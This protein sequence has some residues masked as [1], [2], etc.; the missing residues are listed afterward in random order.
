V[1]RS[2]PYQP[3][4]LV[5]RQV[6]ESLPTDFTPIQSLDATERALFNT[7]NLW[8]GTSGQTLSDNSLVIAAAEAL[9]PSRQIAGANPG[10]GQTLF[11]KYNPHDND[12]PAASIHWLQFVTTNAP[13]SMDQQAGV[14]FIDNNG[15]T[16]LPFYDQVFTADTTGLA[17]LSKRDVSA[18]TIQWRAELFLVQEVPMFGGLQTSYVVW[19]GL[20]WGWRTTAAPPAMA[21]VT[22]NAGPTG[23]GY[24]VTITGDGFTDATGVSFGGVAATS[25]TVNSDTSITATVPAH[26]IGTLDVAVTT[27]SGVS[28]LLLDDQFTY[29]DAAT[30]VSASANPATAG[31]TETFTANVTPDGTG[32]WYPT[33]TVSF[34]ADNNLLGTNALSGMGQATLTV[35]N[36]TA[37]QPTIT[38][39]YSGDTEFGSSSAS[40]S[41]TVNLNSVIVMTNIPG[42]V[43]A[44]QTF[45][46]AATVDGAGSA[47]PTGTV[48]FTLIDA[49]GNETQL[50]TDTVNGSG[51]SSITASVATPGTYHVRVTY[52]GDADYFAAS[53]TV[54]LN[55]YSPPPPLM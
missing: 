41:L 13:I 18:A 11:L 26:P 39:V 34:Y 16:T 3:P 51:Y 35:N 6:A 9:G 37:G 29:F 8:Y 48:T 21:S 53:T 7:F 31:T 50:G 46:L 45:T 43:E 30:S 20:R 28:D 22:P 1:T 32:N 55:V 19:Q 54:D 14:Q 49:N 24:A 47:I 5:G 17:D 23:G 52:S 4:G 12:P 38:A 33:G 25:F 2:D 27:P 40:M 44:G 42:G 15:S 10:V 36:L